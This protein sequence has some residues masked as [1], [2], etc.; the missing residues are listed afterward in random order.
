MNKNFKKCA[1]G[2]LSVALLASGTAFAKN[3][4]ETIEAA[5]SNIKIYVDG[6]IVETKDVNG[7]SVEPFIYNGTTYL[8]VRAVGE[9]VGKEVSWDGETRSV[10][11]VTKETTE[12]PTEEPEIVEPDT[13][14]V[15]VKNETKMIEAAYSDIKIYVDGTIVE[16]KDVNGNSVEP[17]IY[18]GT[19]YLPVRAV[20]EAVG[21]EVG[22]DGETRSVFLTTKEEAKDPEVKDPATEDPAEEPE[23]V[24][25]EKV[26]LVLNCKTS[27][28]N[29]YTPY[30][31]SVYGFVTVGGQD[32]EDCFSLRMTG[33]NMSP[34]TPGYVVFDLEEKYDTMTFTVGQVDNTG[35]FRGELKVYV[36]DTLA[37]TCALESD[38]PGTQE[39]TINL[40]KAKNVKLEIDGIA[41]FPLTPEYGIVNA[42]VH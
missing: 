40:N 33:Q 26:N 42:I 39:V 23:V 24:E 28:E 10:Y 30:L 17:F 8:P 18:N 16:T 34:D 38:K 31:N 15:E 32:Y 20:G 6:A 22:W 25:K 41:G 12:E 21:K 4:T 13:A 3:A 35:T 27:G 19:T 9:A 11:L 29:G 14:V 2:V 37:E 36:D 1:A 7:N 5:Y